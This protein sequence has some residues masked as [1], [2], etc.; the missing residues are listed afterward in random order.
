MYTITRSWT[1]ES[2]EHLDTI[3]KDLNK[4][5]CVVSTTYTDCP[6]TLHVQYLPAGRHSA[7][8]ARYSLLHS[9]I[10]RIGGKPA[11]VCVQ[12]GECGKAI[13][14]P[15]EY[16]SSVNYCQTCMEY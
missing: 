4:Y 12:C 5:P 9:T 2:S 7:N 10:A 16:E 3:V 11:V 6:I 14:V 13:E 1:F 15:S 8:M